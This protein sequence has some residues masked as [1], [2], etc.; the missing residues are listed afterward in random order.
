MQKLALAQK[1][2]NKN[3]HKISC[4]VRL[5]LSSAKKGKNRN[6]R[7]IKIYVYTHIVEIVKKELNDLF[8][9]IYK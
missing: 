5:L 8:S 1:R 2:S 7:N 9:V 4:L 6:E 3:T